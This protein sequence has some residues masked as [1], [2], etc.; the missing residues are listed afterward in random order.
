[1]CYIYI[2]LICSN[3]GSFID[4]KSQEIRPNSA[5]NMKKSSPEPLGQ[6]QPNRCDG[7]ML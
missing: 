5:G 6:L 2:P 3:L 4:F 7:Q 1:M